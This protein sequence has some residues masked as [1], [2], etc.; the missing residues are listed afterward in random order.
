[1]KDLQ[2]GSAC[3]SVLQ[4]KIRVG[5]NPW[6]HF[7]V[8]SWLIAIYILYAT[9]QLSSGG[10]GNLGPPKKLGKGTKCTQIR[11]KNYYLLFVL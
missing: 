8:R 9:D 4:L 11:N 10:T 2:P 5:A 1:M 7:Y 6:L 3:L